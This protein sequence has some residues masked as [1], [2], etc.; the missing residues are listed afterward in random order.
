MT[1]KLILSF[2]IIL[3]LVSA[4]S[5]QSALSHR[6]RAS[7]LVADP[8]SAVSELIAWAEKTQGYY[9]Y[10]SSEIVV[11]RFPSEYTAELRPFLLDISEYLVEY[12]PEA[13]DQGDEIVNLESGIR[14]R[15][16]ILQ[17]NLDYLDKAD[18]MGTLAIE[19]EVMQL[20]SEIES[21]KG[22]LKK[23]RQDIR[24]GYAEIYLSFQ[25]QSLPSSIPSSFS[26]INTLDFYDFMRE[27][28]Q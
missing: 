10:S 2:V 11:L 4:L 5:A 28:G 23:I 9:L 26:W 6:V 21:M 3:F 18:V 17:R 12:I 7:V 22:R 1:K 16:E 27:T 25:Q 20:L 14:S 13:Y 19:R 24:Y 15:E 8:E